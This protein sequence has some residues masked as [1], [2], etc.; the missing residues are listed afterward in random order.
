MTPKNLKING[1]TA[2]PNPIEIDLAN[3]PTGLICVVG[4]NGAG[5]TTIME[6]MAPG[7][8]FREFPSRPSRRG[9]LEYATHRQAVVD[10]TMD[11]GGREIRLLHQLDPDYSNGRGKAEAFVLV[12]G[13]PMVSGR[14]GDFDELVASLLPSRAVFLASAYAA[15]NQA[16]N[17]TSMP[18]AKRR[19]LFAE[20]L[21]LGALQDLALRA[22][23]HRKLC[24]A[25]AGELERRSE[26]LDIDATRHAELTIAHKLAIK[27]LSDLVAH[28]R[29]IKVEADDA[30][31]AL[32]DA[33]ATASHADSKRQQQ[34]SRRTSLAAKVNR[35]TIEASEA[36]HELANIGHGLD[37]VYV[38]TVEADHSKRIKLTAE[39]DELLAEW[40]AIEATIKAKGD[41]YNR[42]KPD[43]GTRAKR[44]REIQ[45][46]QATLTR[47]ETVT[48]T[49]L[50]SADEQV[51]EATRRRND[52]RVPSAMRNPDAVRLE[53]A[54][55]KA[56]ASLV[57]AVPCEGKRVALWL[58]PDDHAS[59]TLRD[60]GDCQLLAGAVTARDLVPTLAAELATT[61]AAHVAAL[62]AEAALQ[63]AQANLD[64]LAAKRRN[65]DLQYECIQQ[66]SHAQGMH[67]RVVGQLADL[68][69]EID[70]AMTKRGDIT[71]HGEEIAV[72]LKVL[73]DTD[74]ALRDIAAARIRQPEVAARA[75]QAEQLRDEAAAELEGLPAPQ[76]VDEG[77]QRAVEA[78]NRHAHDKAK[79]LHKHSDEVRARTT[80]RDELAGQLK[81]LG[82]VADKRAAL[83]QSIERYGLRRRGFA[84]IEQAVGREGI[85]A[86]EIDAAGPEVSELATELLRKAAGARFTVELRTI[87]EA[88]GNRK[89]REVFDL[90]VYDGKR[91]GARS[92][93]DLSGGEQTLVDEALKL[94][95]AVFNARR[96]GSIKTLWRDEADGKLDPER[97][98]AYPAMLRAA[99]ELGGFER[100]YY[101]SHDPIVQAQADAR[102]VVANGAVTVEA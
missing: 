6:C 36:R 41:E 13:E 48:D 93:D 94:A 8:M 90:L 38:A 87:S 61:E 1:V 14:S 34:I 3:L 98:A 50:E 49:E 28:G 27:L 57:D 4:P 64:D 52:L 55:A 33:R 83:A 84:L 91:A 59:D 29:Q 22:R 62:E 31:Q 11:Y 72:E 89:A 40:R 56:D 66:L 92:F 75:K 67:D 30:N 51:Q 54:R 39:R 15:Q 19:E 24:D 97:R 73:G 96:H 68:K 37:P 45:A 71:S 12:D 17:F 25:G 70:T 47:V 23:E 46:T 43:K 2:F 101:V 10:L 100:L 81:H 53:F 82:A 42:L 5:K 63:V 35:H 7:A 76:D 80:D 78:A 77:L 74:T 99:L 79:A 18:Q 86:L 26:R 21:G 65:G 102:I 95:I 58:H 32:S 85:Q 20:L 16:G 44:V 88:E 60:C 69:A 9:L